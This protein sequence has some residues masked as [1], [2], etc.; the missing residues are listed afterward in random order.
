MVIGICTRTHLPWFEE[1]KKACRILGLECKAIRIGEDDWMDQVRGIDAF[2]WRV[3]MGDPS[4]MAEA[5]IKIPL[6]EEMGIPCF[7]N[8]KMLWF[9]DDKIRESLFF[10][11]NRYPTPKTSI[12]FDETAARQYAE[13]AEYP[14]V[15]KSH[16]GAGSSGVSLLR[17]P[18]E[19]RRLLDRIFRQNSLW[20]RMVA[21]FYTTPRLKRGDLLLALRHHFRDSWPRYAYFQEFVHTDCDWRITTL[22]PNLVSVFV[23]RNRPKD[24][25]ASGSGLWE[26]VTLEDLPT[27]ACDLAL[28]ISNTHGFTSMTYDFMRHRGNWVIGEM[29]YSFLLND[30]YTETL[31]LRDSNG[32]RTSEPIPVGVMHLCALL[33]LSLPEESP[34]PPSTRSRDVV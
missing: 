11:Q 3:I 6:I 13:N 14:I 5:H 10:R 33:D 15:V 32:Y 4:C 20:G 30:V 21:R 19:A 26:K 31:F 25:R 9:F 2:F 8:K 16:C 24:F 27:D 29:S 17:T 18:T 22:G 7:P 12:F 28:H 23:R 1:F 34:I